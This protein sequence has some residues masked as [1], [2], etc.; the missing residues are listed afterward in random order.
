MLMCIVFVF[1]VLIH[2][3]IVICLLRTD[4]KRSA[5]FVDKLGAITIPVLFACFNGIYWTHLKNSH[6]L[7]E[8]FSG[9]FDVAEQHVPD[10]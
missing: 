9:F 6:S 8:S 7:D 5:D 3:V 4:N 10:T 1:I 2:F